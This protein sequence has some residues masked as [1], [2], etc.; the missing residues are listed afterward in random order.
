MAYDDDEW[1]QVP[2]EWLQDTADEKPARATRSSPRKSK[3][4]PRRVSSPPSPPPDDNE[5]EA[6]ENAAEWKGKDDLRT[7]LGSD[8]AISDLT[9]LS[10]D[11]AEP[12]EEVAKLAVKVEVEALVT[13]AP[14]TAMKDPQLKGEKSNQGPEYLGLD[15]I[16]HIPADFVEWEAVSCLAPQPVCLSAYDCRFVLHSR[17]GR[18]LANDLPKLLTT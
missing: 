17:N 4:Q 18:K 15:T 3:A 7:G 16:N 1:Q 11:Q 2:E 10:D 12:E 6:E 5:E 13:N 14:Q 8:D 9:E